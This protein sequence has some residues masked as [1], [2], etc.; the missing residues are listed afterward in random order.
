MDRCGSVVKRSACELLFSKCADAQKEQGGIYHGLVNRIGRLIRKDAGG[1]AG[2]NLDHARFMRCLQ[3]IV[4]DVN[5][6]PLESK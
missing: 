4:I 5:V 6:V 3:H 2:N 1:Q